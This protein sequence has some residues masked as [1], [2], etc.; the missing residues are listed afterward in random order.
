MA[1]TG[2]IKVLESI[3]GSSF[4]ASESA[5]GVFQ[6]HKPDIEH[7]SFEV[8]RE[9][10]SELVV[11]TEG[12]TQLGVRTGTAVE[13][14]AQDLKALT[15]NRARMKVVDTIQ[16]SNFLSMRVA[17]EVFRRHKPDLSEY[18]IEVV[19]D[20]DSLVVLFSDKN[21]IRGTRGSVGR[22]GFEVALDPR[23]RRVT[24]SNFVR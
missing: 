18:R 8:L 4:L 22:P 5:M 11:F 20:G 3:Q 12:Q 21:R 13:L 15:S 23:D 9:G 16:G 19:R 6:S 17:A 24:R 1:T 14:N 7:G 10:D 2:Q